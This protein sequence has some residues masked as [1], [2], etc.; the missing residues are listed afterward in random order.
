MSAPSR[1]DPLRE[2]VWAPD[3]ARTPEEE[4]LLRA[5]LAECADCRAAVEAARRVA[6]S[7]AALPTVAAPATFR[8]RTL[9]ELDARRAAA[10]AANGTSTVAAPPPSLA[11]ARRRSLPIALRVALPVAATL[12]LAVAWWQS[13]EEFLAPTLDA[14]APRELADDERERRLAL[15][16]QAPPA[17]AA[18]AKAEKELGDGE[19]A[20]EREATGS[21][22]SGLASEVE[23][24]WK[25]DSKE[26]ADRSD[27]PEDASVAS[28]RGEGRV[29]GV[30]GPP[31][32]P[33]PPGAAALPEAASVDPPVDPLGEKLLAAAT[34]ADALRLVATERATRYGNVL[35]GGLDVDAEKR[36]QSEAK[37][38]PELPPLGK[39]GGGGGE[40]RR[41]G[42]VA[43]GAGARGGG[44][45]AGAEKSG[46]P[47]DGA[48]PGGAK[49][50]GSLA[51][52]DR[53]E[54][55]A[56]PPSELRYAEW[57][58]SSPHEIEL[59]AE[60]SKRGAREGD[61]LVVD[62]AP[63]ELE[64]TK[65]AGRGLLDFADDDRRALR[66][67][68]D[69]AQWWKETS[70]TVDLAK[71]KSAVEP[72]GG[73]KSEAPP[74]PT[75]GVPPGAPKPAAEPKSRAGTEPEKSDRDD[76]TR[77]DEEARAAKARR[78][79]VIVRLTGS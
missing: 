19:T 52:A 53:A 46:D 2:L 6:A 17:E 20:S 29:G 54:Q 71:L 5:H 57:S 33:P 74:A 49:K 79:R 9:A 58:P 63:E 43:K 72:T 41:D 77:H 44:K 4:A 68:D 18:G 56:A 64:A 21:D 73:A 61:L 25:S 37:K 16:P 45:P 30:G 10:T 48:G 28:G 34:P 7:L 50:R 8:E 1:C 13:R 67:V 60:W 38:A 31:G 47:K 32:A 42:E 78:V 15:E 22:K 14:A 76:A 35:D 12:L 51:E 24:E 36:K 55:A 69:P 23:G 40:V 70:S 59:L 75:T 27:L 26:S 65:F 11:A 66:S 3:G 62:L 39:G